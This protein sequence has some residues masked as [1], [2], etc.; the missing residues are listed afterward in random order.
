MQNEYLN[1]PSSLVQPASQPTNQPI[2][3]PSMTNDIIFV[4][5]LEFDCLLPSPT[6]TAITFATVVVVIVDN[7]RNIITFSLSL[8]NQEWAADLLG[9]KKT[10]RAA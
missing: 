5:S 1:S 10:K 6:T 3:Q 9:E 7:V 2:S 4:K 8:T